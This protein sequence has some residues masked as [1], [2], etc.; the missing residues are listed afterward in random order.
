MCVGLTPGLSGGHI[1]KLIEFRH[2]LRE[3]VVG[4]VLGREL[5]TEEQ[6]ALPQW[7]QQRGERADLL[8]RPAAARGPVTDGEFRSHPGTE[9]SFPAGRWLVRVEAVR[10]WAVPGPSWKLTVWEHSG[11]GRE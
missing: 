9:P 6:G 7:I 3:T 10:P 8:E 4:K 5:R 2:W 11:E 1:P